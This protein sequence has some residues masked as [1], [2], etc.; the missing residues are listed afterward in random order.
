MKNDKLNPNIANHIIM[1]F[2]KEGRPLPW[3]ETKDPYAILVSEIM[4][5]QTQVV[6]VIP[7]YLRFLETLPTIKDLANVSED[8]LHSLWEG[9][10]YYSRASRLKQFAVTVMKD[11]KG[12]IPKDKNDLIK[13]PGIGPYTLGALLSFAFEE[14]EPAVDGN[15]KRVLA[16]LMADQSDV[17]KMSTTKAYTEEVKK[18]LPDDIYSFNQGIIELGALVCKPKN[19][20][21]HICPIRAYCKAFE[22]SLIDCIPNKPKK[23]KQISLRVPVFIIEDRGQVLFVKRSLKGLLSGLYGLPMIEVDTP[24]GKEL[25]AL[26]DYFL[27]NFDYEVDGDVKIKKC[28]EIKH[29]FSHR[30]WYEQ[31]YC[32]SLMHLRERT[33]IVEYPISKWSRVDEISIPTAFRKALDLWDG[34]GNQ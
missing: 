31:V 24:E 6:T 12:I 22:N 20:N 19:P 7:Y 17:T 1:W 23:I 2:K 11:Y 13:L 34:K 26:K 28:G 18:I 9:L 33:E 25:E 5:Q 8:V 4:L 10:G 30:V 27:D 29:V 21:C 15:V 16:R 14:K 3:R 32:L